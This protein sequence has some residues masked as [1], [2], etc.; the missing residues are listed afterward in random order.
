MVVAVVVVVVALVLAPVLALV[1]EHAVVLVLRL[2]GWG[3]I[4]AAPVAAVVASAAEVLVA[5]EPSLFV[6]VLN[7]LQKNLGGSLGLKA[8]MRSW[9]SKIASP[10]CTKVLLG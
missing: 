3:P 1:S 9:N 6:E 8:G 4:A 10:S 7:L 5:V 2:A